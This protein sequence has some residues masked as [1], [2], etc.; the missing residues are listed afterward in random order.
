MTTAYF[1]GFTILGGLIAVFAISGWNSYTEG[2]LP[3][4][5]IIFRWFLAGLTAAG[6]SAYAWLF[7]AGGDPAKMMESVSQAFEV[8]QILE[9]LSTPVGGAV[10]PEPELKTPLKEK[11]KEKEKNTE[12]SVG[13]PNF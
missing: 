13:M 3:D 4:T 11:E 5:P 1:I 6:L 8:K 10:E 2:K 9:K 7:G 12:I